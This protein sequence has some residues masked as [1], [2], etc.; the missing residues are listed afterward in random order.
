MAVQDYTSF[1]GKR[2][3]F[4]MPVPGSS[5][6]SVTGVIIANI[7]YAQ[8]YDKYE[9]D[10][11]LFLQDGHKDPDFIPLSSYHDFHVID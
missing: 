3:G 10:A 11:V 4:T 6:V 1:L 2:V 9:D 7:N 8:G 5:D